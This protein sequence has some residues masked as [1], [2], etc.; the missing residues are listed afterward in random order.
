MGNDG[1]GTVPISKIRKQVRARWMG[2]GTAFRG[3]PREG[4][5]ITIDGNTEQGPSPMDTLLL[6]LAACMGADIVSILEKS[7]VP[8]ESF[9]VLA[10]GERAEEHPRRYL[11]IEVVYTAK[12]P[13]P[14][15]QAKLDRAVELSR[16]KYCSFTHSLSS[17]IALD[18]RIERV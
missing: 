4:V 7:R 6:G 15:H 12:G 16:D 9:E 8:L 2:E 10:R 18:V 11:K 17:D 5:E 3:G 1:K 13:G 14:Q